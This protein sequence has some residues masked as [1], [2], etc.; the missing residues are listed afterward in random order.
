MAETHI[1]YRLWPIGN[2]DLRHHQ[3]FNHE[4]HET[5]EGRSRFPEGPANHA[6]GRESGSEVGGLATKRHKVA[7]AS[8][9]TSRAPIG[10]MATLS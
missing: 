7:V 6:N 5:H 8:N 3:S 10:A 9:W 2:C 4:K 1:G